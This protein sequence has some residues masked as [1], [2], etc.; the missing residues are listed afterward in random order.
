MASDGGAGPKEAVQQRVEVEAREV[1]RG[2]KWQTPFVLLG[3]V[4]ATI[5][6]V[7]ALISAVALLL[8][9]LV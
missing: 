1:S 5:F 3:S 2:R 6:V 4:A 8:W 7:V 9:W